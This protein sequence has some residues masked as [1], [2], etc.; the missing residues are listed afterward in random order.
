MLWGDLPCIVMG[1]KS[2]EHDNPAKQVRLD[3]DGEGT[4]VQMG[5]KYRVAAKSGVWKV[6]DINPHDDMPPIRDVLQVAQVFGKSEEF[7]RERT[8]WI[9]YHED[10][11]P[12]ALVEKG[13]EVD[14]VSKDPS[15]SYVNRYDWGNHMYD[16]GYTT[17][18]WGDIDPDSGWAAAL[19]RHRRRDRVHKYQMKEGHPDYERWE[20]PGYYRHRK[21]FLFDAAH[22]P[23][24]V[25][26]TARWVCLV[27]RVFS[28]SASCLT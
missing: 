19:E 7:G 20:R 18:T 4:I 2:T 6:S 1:M 11:S 23:S 22:G 3:S 9:V 21:I 8:G 12:Q 24:V 14:F 27:L 17:R 10:E 25:K 13:V 16:W 15:I 28:S 26:F 5:W